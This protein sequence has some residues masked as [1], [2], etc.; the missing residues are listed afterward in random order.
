[1]C[2]ETDPS[3]NPSFKP[4]VRLSIAELDE[5]KKQL[6]E[7]LFKNLIKSSTSPYG[8]PVLFVKKANGSLRMCVDRHPLLRIN[9]LID[10]F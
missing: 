10:R 9:G 3:A 5:L 6:N 4:A 2:I 8:A 7:L 1:M